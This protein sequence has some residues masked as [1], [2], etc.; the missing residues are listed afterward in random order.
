M[1]LLLN[2]LPARFL[3]TL[4][5][6]FDYKISHCVL[7][8]SLK[9]CCWSK[10]VTEGVHQMTQIVQNLGKLTLHTTRGTNDNMSRI[11]AST[12]GK[13]PWFP[14]VHHNQKPHWKPSDPKHTRPTHLAKFERLL[15]WG[16]PMTEEVKRSSW[17][18]ERLFV[19]MGWQSIRND[20][21]RPSLQMFPVATAGIMMEG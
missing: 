5:E 9:H 1:P 16:L 2:L 15:F 19:S 11:S 7:N 6:W 13:T 17:S 12:F 10:N 20:P 4:R 8:F 21:P 18:W 14:L 3:L